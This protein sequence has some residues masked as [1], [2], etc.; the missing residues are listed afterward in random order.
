MDTDMTDAGYDIDI[1]VG[2][3]VAAPAQQPQQI[4]EQTPASKDENSM[5]AAYYENLDT[6]PHKAWPEC[7]NLQGVE[8]FDPNDPLYYAMEAIG[9]EPRVKQLR[10]VSDSSVNLEFY[11]SEDAAAAL[12]LLTHEEAGDPNSYALQDSRRAKT[13]TKKPN[14]I[15][16]LREANDG[17]QKPK[18]AANRS[19]YYQ[20]NPDVRGNREREPRKRQPPQR[21]F[22]DYGE[23]DSGSRDSRPRRR[24]NSGDESMDEDSGVERRRNNTFRRNDRDNRDTRG[25]GGRRNDRGRDDRNSGRLRDDRE[26]GRL[27]ADVDSYRPGSRSPRE[28]HFGRLRGRSASPTSNDGDGRFGFAEDNSNLRT[29]YRSRSRS[30]NP[31]RRREPSADRWT[32]DRANYGTSGGRW[33]TDSFIDS[34]PMGNHRRSDAMDSTGKG[35]SLLSRMTKDG[36][37]VVPQTRSLADRITRDDDD[38]DHSYGRLKGDDREPAFNDFSEPKPRRNLVD[39]ISR[40]TDINIRGRSQEGINIKGAGNGS[41]GGGINIRG[42]ASGA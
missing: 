34:S 30:R 13:Y 36:R 35:A 8:D 22:L 17:D 38:D 39:R 15:L 1:D 40:D 16:R 14:S 3:P 31:R 7:L 20:R 10:W 12:A 11:S 21:D 9:S 6:Q 5:P 19:T 4:I 28:T 42:V 18:G 27:G 25:R 26:S 23:E 37:P 2:A 32:H 33:Q 41:S 29:R 24:R